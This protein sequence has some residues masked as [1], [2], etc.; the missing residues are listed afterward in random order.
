[1]GQHPYNQAGKA[2]V[3]DR[4]TILI[5]VIFDRDDILKDPD[6]CKDPADTQTKTDHGD[7]AA[8][9]PE[10]RD[11]GES[12]DE[13]IQG[14]SEDRSYHILN[15]YRYGNGGKNEIE[16]RY[17]KEVPDLGPELAECVCHHSPAY[18]YIG[19]LQIKSMKQ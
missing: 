9:H 4:I 3:R 11:H 7:R 14:L 8:Q 19:V 17:K 1:M 18:P 2:L 12:R 16:Q 5:E 15:T 10:T 6:R 13:G